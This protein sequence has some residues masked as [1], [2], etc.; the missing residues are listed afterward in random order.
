MQVHVTDPWVFRPYEAYLRMLAAVLP[1]LPAEE[2]W[3]AET[4]EFVSD[5]AAIDLLTG[6]PGFRTAV[7]DAEA[8]EDTLG[9][10]AR[11]AAEFDTERRAV[12]LYEK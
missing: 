10:E 6:G 1:S 11:G 8:L 7:D 2:R 3:R 12:W 4:Y 9:A 5:R